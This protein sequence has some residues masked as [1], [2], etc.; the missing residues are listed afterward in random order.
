MWTRCLDAVDCAMYVLAIIHSIYSEELIE[1]LWAGL[2]SSIYIDG[3]SFT[4]LL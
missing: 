2:E 1:Q 4:E 3:F